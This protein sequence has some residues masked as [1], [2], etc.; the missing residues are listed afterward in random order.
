LPPRSRGGTHVPVFEIVDHHAVCHWVVIDDQNPRWLT[1][2]RAHHRIVTAECLS[3]ISAAATCSD[4]HARNSASASL[5]AGDPARLLEPPIAAD[6]RAWCG[7]AS[8][9]R[10]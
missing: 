9:N 2:S 8:S 3:L 6:R 7:V 5:G 1:A 4:I 10:P